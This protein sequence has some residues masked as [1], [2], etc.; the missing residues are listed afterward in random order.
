MGR[1]YEVKEGE[2]DYCRCRPED[3]DWD[4]VSQ[5]ILRDGRWREIFLDIGVKGWRLGL[6][7][8]TCY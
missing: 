1:G 3:M 4:A 8:T 6:F 2:R 5:G 7:M